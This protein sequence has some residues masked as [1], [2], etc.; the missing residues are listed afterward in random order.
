MEEMM[1]LRTEYGGYAGTAEC[2]QEATSTHTL[3]S[4]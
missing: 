2:I 4:I 1:V 3:V